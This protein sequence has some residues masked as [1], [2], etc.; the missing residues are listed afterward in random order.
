MDWTEG[1]W[2]LMDED[3]EWLSTS[4]GTATGAARP[5]SCGC[6]WGCSDE[7]TLMGG[8]WD[9]EESLE[10]HEGLCSI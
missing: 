3:L 8:D 9:E 4:A 5:A 7:G 1:E 10:T 2:E 6:Q